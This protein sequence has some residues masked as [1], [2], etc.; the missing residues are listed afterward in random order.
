MIKFVYAPEAHATPGK[1]EGKF[2]HTLTRHEVDIK[3]KEKLLCDSLPSFYA[4][5]GMME[6]FLY[7]LARN[8]NLAFGGEWK[9][10]I[11]NGRYSSEGE[12]LLH[13]ETDHYVIECICGQIHACIDLL[14]RAYKEEFSI[15]VTFLRECKV[16]RIMTS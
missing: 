9:I 11:Q 7:Q 2:L 10:K 15:E 13:R 14:S 12:F 6:G 8:T 4:Q 1:D 5:A 3:R 16:S